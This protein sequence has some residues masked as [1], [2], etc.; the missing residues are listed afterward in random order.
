MI[1][2]VSVVFVYFAYHYCAVLVGHVMSQYYYNLMFCDK[3]NAWLFCKTISSSPLP[4]HLHLLTQIAGVYALSIQSMF[5]YSAGQ[6]YPVVLIMER[7]YACHLKIR[8]TNDVFATL[9]PI[10]QMLLLL[11]SCSLAR[12]LYYISLL[13]EFPI[14]FSYS[15]LLLAFLLLK[16]IHFAFYLLYPTWTC[17]LMCRK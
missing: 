3:G 8:F 14:Q 17:R 13:Y 4:R 7:L 11:V 6:L 1:S 12:K 15:S 10:S 5:E 9:K 16:S 2:V